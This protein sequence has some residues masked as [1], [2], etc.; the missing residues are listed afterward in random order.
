MTDTEPYEI[1]DSTDWL[2]TPLPGL[3]VVESALRCQ[4]CKDFYKTPMLT[5]CNH[6]FCSICIRRALSNDGR[7][8][9]CRAGEQEMKLRSNWSMEETVL[10][11]TKTRREVLD[12]AQR[13]PAVVA[14]VTSPK[15]RQEDGDLGEQREAK[16]LRS[17]ARLSASKGAQVTAEMARREADTPAA[18]EPEQDLYIDDGLVAC[19]ICLTRMK[20]VKVDKHLDES[21]LGSP[22]PESHRRPRSRGQVSLTPTLPN[23]FQTLSNQAAPSRNLERLPVMNYSMLKEPQLRKKLSELGISSAGNR[24]MLEKRH[25]EWMTI[26]NA[27]CDSLRPRRKTELL[28]DLDTWERTLGTQAP[29]SSRSM[30]QGQQIKDKGF[31]QAAWSS[32]H[33][34][35]FKDLI[36]S[37]K[38]NMAHAEKQVMEGMPSSTEQSDA[39]EAAHATSGSTGLITPDFSTPM[40]ATQMETIATTPHMTSGKEGHITIMPDLTREAGGPRPEKA[41]FAGHILDTLPS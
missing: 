29:V 8:P 35:S 24:P 15:R 39:P 3:A 25:K 33:D 1:T 16:R 41:D 37:A 11:F 9:L 14:S 34:D 36:A 38:K 5:S 4:V 32:K 31:D 10:A 7:C 18:S 21:C 28:H 22:Q 12:F 30:R 2:S 40:S 13:P 6:T 27:N 26:W 20:E 23:G 19:P 17:S